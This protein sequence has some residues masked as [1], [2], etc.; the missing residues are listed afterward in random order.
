M[1]LCF[2]VAQCAALTPEGRPLGGLRPTDRQIRGHSQE[3]SSRH[4][5]IYLRAVH[6]RQQQANFARRSV[7]ESD[8]PPGRLSVEP[9]GSM[10]PD[11]RS[12]K[13]QES[14]RTDRITHD[15][16]NA[17]R[18]GD[19]D[20]PSRRDQVWPAIHA[21]ATSLTHSITI[22]YRPPSNLGSVYQ[23]ACQR[24][25]LVPDTRQEDD[26]LMRSFAGNA[27]QGSDFRPIQ[28]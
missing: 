4:R 28:R 6:D 22:P 23:R 2:V 1:L 16:T 13:R 18:R 27:D 3:D 17:A 7:G 21:C 10:S 5:S 11:H 15:H 25:V 20:S 14:Q 12:P 24:E 8:P 26:G 19:R 9:N